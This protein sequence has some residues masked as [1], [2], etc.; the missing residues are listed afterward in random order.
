[1]M[2]MMT[3]LLILLPLLPVSL[4]HLHD[5]DD[6]VSSSC[7]IAP[8]RCIVYGLTMTL[9]AGVAGFFSTL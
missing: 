8:L 4:L 9:N 6:Y 5:D 7:S 2:M 3:L 1:M